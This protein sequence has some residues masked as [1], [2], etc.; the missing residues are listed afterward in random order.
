MLLNTNL[1]CG[2]F[3][4]LACSSQSNQSEISSYEPKYKVS[5]EDV[6][7]WV[8]ERNKMEQCLYPKSVVNNSVTLPDSQQ[9]LYHMAVYSQTLNQIIGA[10]NYQAL[11]QDPASQQ[12]LSS[13]L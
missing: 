10:D 2:P 3:M 11:M 6:K 13:K 7:K 12:Y 9:F 5:N 4:L 1:D 8:I